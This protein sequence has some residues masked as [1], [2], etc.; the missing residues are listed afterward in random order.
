MASDGVITADEISAAME[1]MTKKDAKAF[2]EMV[3]RFISGG[4][5]AGAS[6]SGAFVLATDQATDGF[7]EFRN[8]TSVDLEAM[9]AD[10]VITA[11]EISEAMK[12]MTETDSR[13]FGE[14]VQGFIDGGDLQAESAEETAARAVAAQRAAK[15]KILASEG[16]KFARLAA[17]EAAMALGSEATEEQR[18]EAARNAAES[19]R[20]SW[21]VALC[22]VGEADAA[23]TTAMGGQAEDRTTKASEE[24]EKV[25][26][27]IE[28]TM[29]SGTADKPSIVQS[30]EQA[31]R[32]MAAAFERTRA[33]GVTKFGQLRDGANSAIGA[34]QRFVNVNVHTSYTSSGESGGPGG[35]E[36]GLQGGT[37]GLYGAFG[38]G[39][40][41]ILHGLE[42]V[43]PR[44]T[45]PTLAG[46][47]AA[48]LVSMSGR[49]PAVAG[50]PPIQVEARIGDSQLDRITDEVCGGPSAG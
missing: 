16:D 46:D 10:G 43:V 33:S 35:G 21:T 15:E 17:F 7:A 8:N 13:L 44:F 20:E 1:G 23:A 36:V 28:N 48:A 37:H 18:A 2:K 26:E 22:V 4:D 50:G 5:L 34:I 9:A 3:D 30:G 40:A 31:E 12:G 47:L 42:A 29:V 14:M 25:R 6:I 39:T 11:G 49:Q 27:D 45:V 24:S 38:R 19:A 32:D 41:R